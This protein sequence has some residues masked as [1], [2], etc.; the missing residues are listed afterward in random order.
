MISDFTLV[1]CW[2]ISSNS[3]PIRIPA[4]LF[5]VE[6]ERIQGCECGLQFVNNSAVKRTEKR[7]KHEKLHKRRSPPNTSISSNIVAIKLAQVPY[8]PTQ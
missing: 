4:S 2:R 6:L 3:T 7:R 1:R 5:G 8:D